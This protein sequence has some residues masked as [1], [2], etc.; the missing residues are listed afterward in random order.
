MALA[1]TLI[2]NE[3]SHKYFQFILDNPDKPWHYSWLSGNPNITW[4]IIQLNPDKPW[5]YDRLSKNPNITWEIIQQN[6]DKPWNYFC[7]SNNNQT[8]DREQFINDILAHIKNIYIF[9][10]ELLIFLYIHILVVY[11]INYSI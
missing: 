2:L 5:D 10:V 4:D 7:L 3:W 6:P 11:Y 8:F 9:S 1:K